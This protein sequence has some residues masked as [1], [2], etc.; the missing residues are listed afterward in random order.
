M[1]HTTKVFSHQYFKTGGKRNIGSCCVKPYFA[2]TVHGDSAFSVRSVNI[3][4]GKKVLSETGDEVLNIFSTHNTN[5]KRV[6]IFTDKKVGQLPF[7]GEVTASLKKSGI[8]F[9]IYDEVRVEPTDASFMNA[10]HFVRD[11]NIDL[12]ISVGGGSVMDTTKAAI[13]YGKNP[14]PNDDFLYVRPLIH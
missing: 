11:S 7:F 14:P 5:G 2:E 6:G 1:F 13:L 10:A 9:V 12:A 8:D 3:K 4:F